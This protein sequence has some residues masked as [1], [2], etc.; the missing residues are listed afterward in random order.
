MKRMMDDYLEKF[1][2]RLTERSRLMHD[3]NYKMAKNM[4]AWKEKLIKNWDSIQVMDMEVTDTDNFS[5][6]V[7]DPFRAKIRL[8]LDGIEPEYIGLEAVFFHRTEDEELEQRLA[9]QLVLKEQEGPTA[10]FECEI[11]PKMSGVYEYGFRLYP[12]HP[13]LPHRQDLELA[14]WL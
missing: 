5:L 14:R 13:E 4:A 11:L 3:K 6:T 2:S 7:G 12:K 8:H 1:Y 10:L 9:Q